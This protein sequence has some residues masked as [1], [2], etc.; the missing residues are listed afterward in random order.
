MNFLNLNVS[1][2]YESGPTGPADKGIV[3]GDVCPDVQ[4]ILCVTSSALPAVSGTSVPVTVVR[5]ST[6]ALI[7]ASTTA[8]SSAAAST[9]SKSAA[10]GRHE[11]DRSLVWM[12]F[13]GTMIVMH[14]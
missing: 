10:E 3:R 7:A 4:G 2:K 12:C 14:V 13:I 5:T 11:L 6:S 1:W 9:T 8:S